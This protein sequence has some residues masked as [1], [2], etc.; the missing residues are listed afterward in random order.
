M[1]CPVCGTVFVRSD[2][3]RRYCSAACMES[4][5]RTRHRA[6]YRMTCA[7]QTET[8]AA[9]STG[10]VP[11]GVWYAAVPYGTLAT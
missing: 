8:D 4:A 2:M 7:A 10:P 11:I 6:R 9:F 5:Q 1:F 3:H